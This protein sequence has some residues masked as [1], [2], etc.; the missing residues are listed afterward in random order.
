MPDKFDKIYR[1]SWVQSCCTANLSFI[2]IIAS[3]LCW[4]I[5][6]LHISGSILIEQLIWK[7]R[8]KNLKFSTNLQD[9]VMDGWSLLQS[10]NY[11]QFKLNRKSKRI[12][13]FQSMQ[14]LTWL[15]NITFHLWPF[16]LH[17]LGR[18]R[19]KIMPDIFSKLLRAR[20]RRRLNCLCPL[21]RI[22]GESVDAVSQTG[23]WFIPASF[24][25]FAHDSI[26]NMLIYA[27]FLVFF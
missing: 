23:S 24:K 7:G 4:N 15:S 2:H 20:P 13:W 12:Q 11:F 6:S 5:F 19:S 17:T 16:W 18:N 1:N 14:I 10:K 25:F 9:Q 3:K 21:F 22:W 27:L 26:R 8:I